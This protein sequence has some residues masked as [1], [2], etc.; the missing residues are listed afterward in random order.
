[1]YK[2]KITDLWP[3]PLPLIDG[4]SLLAVDYLLPSGSGPNTEPKVTQLDLQYKYSPETPWAPIHEVVEDRIDRIKRYYW[5]V[6]D[7]GTEVS[8]PPLHAR[9]SSLTDMRF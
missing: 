5:N 6:W 4:Y 3:F 2:L 8:F 7:L 9:Q 1:L